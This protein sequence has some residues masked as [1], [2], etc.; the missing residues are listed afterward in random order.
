MRLSPREPFDP[1]V[2][3]RLVARCRAGD[4]RAWE[5]LVRRYERLVYAIARGYRLPAEDVADVFQEV[6][7]ALVRGLPRLR[8][9]RTLCRWLSSTTERIALATALHRRREASRDAGPVD[10]RPEVV[11]AEGPAGVELEE[12]ENQMRVRLALEELGGSCRALLTALYY[13][14]PAPGYREVS[15]E[16][17]IPI[18]SIGPTR[19]RCLEKLQRLLDREEAPSG[20][21]R[22]APEPT[23]AGEGDHRRRGGSVPGEAIVSV[24]EDRPHVP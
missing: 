9:A 10:L 7:A 12:L 14:D 17:G 1:A 18:G 20:R 4:A 21:I 16:L 3:E 19:A 6:F 22:K 5:T 2:D 15:G 23:S 24:G 8:D 13:R 11:A